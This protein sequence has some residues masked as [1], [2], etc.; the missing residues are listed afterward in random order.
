VG[1]EHDVHAVEVGDDNAGVLVSTKLPVTT[2]SIGSRPGFDCIGQ[3]SANFQPVAI[4]KITP[5]RR[6]LDLFTRAKNKRNAVC[7][8]R[9]SAQGAAVDRR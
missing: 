1:L 9:R 3:L 7:Q 8:R 5:A 6:P 4:R 2:G